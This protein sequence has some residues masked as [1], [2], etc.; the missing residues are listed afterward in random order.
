MMLDKQDQHI[1]SK[2]GTA[3]PEGDWR[4]VEAY[5]GQFYH[6]CPAQYSMAATGE[7]MLTEDEIAGMLLG[8]VIDW[9]ANKDGSE[10]EQ[11]MENEYATELDQEQDT[12]EEEEEG[13]ENGLGSD[14]DEDEESNDS[15]PE[16]DDKEMCTCG[17][18]RVGSCIQQSSSSFCRFYTTILVGL[19]LVWGVGWRD[20]RAGDDYCASLPL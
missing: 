16:E 18:L 17:G 14:E 9:D 2:C 3:Y 12:E 4:V 6:N 5:P 7:S 1:C 15:E 19:L 20:Y 8:T 10:K 13:D 11:G